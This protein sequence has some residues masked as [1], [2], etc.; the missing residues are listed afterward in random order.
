MSVAIRA[1]GSQFRRT[2]GK[3]A[4]VKP[5]LRKANEWATYFFVSV[6]LYAAYTDI[7]HSSFFAAL[8]VVLELRRRA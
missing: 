1:Y 3:W 6:A 7:V 4:R 5:V 2:S 8:A